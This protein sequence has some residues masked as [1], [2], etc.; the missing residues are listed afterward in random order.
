MLLEISYNAV[1]C[2][3]VQIFAD[4][5]VRPPPSIVSVA[6]SSSSRTYRGALLGHVS[7]RKRVAGAAR[8][9]RRPTCWVCSHRSCRGLGLELLFGDAAPPQHSFIDQGTTLAV[10][11]G[12]SLA[13]HQGYNCSAS[14]VQLQC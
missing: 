11:Q 6:D 2:C 9:C 4:V 8:H 14:G 7:P 10:H 12:Y 5:C 1:L 13:V 3:A